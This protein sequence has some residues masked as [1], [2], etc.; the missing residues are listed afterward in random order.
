MTWC[1]K[2][3]Q[4]SSYIDAFHC[5]FHFAM[6]HRSIRPVLI[7]PRMPSAISM[8]PTHPPASSVET[9]G[10]TNPTGPESRGVGK[11]MK[12]FLEVSL[13][14]TYLH[15]PLITHPNKPRD[16]KINCIILRILLQNVAFS[17]TTHFRQL[18]RK[19]ARCQGA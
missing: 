16:R 11:L 1:K 3:H 12:L 7:V 19:S 9:P 8:P 5:S 2:D 4:K 18:S 17:V 15:S 6:F 14:Y 10:S 13:P